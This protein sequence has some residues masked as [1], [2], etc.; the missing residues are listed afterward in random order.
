MLYLQF[1]Y[2]KYIIFTSLMIYWII[3]CNLIYFFWIYFKAKTY[4]VTLCRTLYTLP[5]APC[6]RPEITSKSLEQVSLSSF[7][8]TYGDRKR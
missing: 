1:R 8:Y 3:F 2:D 7:P 4:F 6:P 5:N